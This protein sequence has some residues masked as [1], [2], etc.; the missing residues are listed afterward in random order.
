MTA[1]MLMKVLRCRSQEDKIEKAIPSPPGVT[2]HI[3]SRHVTCSPRYLP[4][5]HTVHHRDFSLFLSGCFFLSR[6]LLTLCRDFPRAARFCKT[7]VD[8]EDGSQT[9]GS[10]NTYVEKGPPSIKNTLE[11]RLGGRLGEGCWADAYPTKTLL[12][13]RAV[14]AWMNCPNKESIERRPYKVNTEAICFSL[15]RPD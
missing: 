3:S 4:S 10:S 1:M 11:E 6:M 8:K 9:S 13:K 15:D 5:I 12:Q 2:Q 14:F 7:H